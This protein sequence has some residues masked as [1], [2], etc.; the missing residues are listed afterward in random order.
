MMISLVQAGEE[1]GLL[2]ESLDRVA[3][4]LEK[5]VV[6]VG[7]IKSAMFYPSFVILFAVAV[8]VVFIAFIL[9]KFKWVFAGMHID[10][11]SPSVGS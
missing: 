11:I 9:P 7:K 4:L 8:V 3:G 2:D 10:S 6:L 5:Q 1:G